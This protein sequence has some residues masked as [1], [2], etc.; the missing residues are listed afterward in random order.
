MQNML[1][2]LVIMSLSAGFVVLLVMI[3]RL[4]LKKAPRQ[5][6][7]ALWILV[8]IRL[9]IPVLPVSKDSIVPRELNDRKGIE[10]LTG[11]YI[12]ETVAVGEKDP[13]FNEIVAQNTVP[14]REEAGQRVAV[15]SR[16]ALAEGRYASPKTVKTAWLPVI[17]LIWCI[18]LGGMLL[19]M[20]FSF[21]RVR[22]KVRV[23]VPLDEKV[24]ACDDIQSPFILGM[25]RPRIYLPLSLSE[26]D[27]AYVLAHEKTHIRRGDTLWK[28]FGFLLLS[29]YWFNPLMWV[30]YIFLCRDIEMACDEAVIKEETHDYRK[31]Y[32]RALLDCSLPRR[33]ITACPLAFG[34][35][36][37][38]SRVKSVLNYRKP[39]FWLVIGALLICLIAAGC[40][41]T[42]PRKA[43]EQETVSEQ[44]VQT[45]EALVK[46][47]KE[48]HDIICSYL[49]KNVFSLYMGAGHK[50]V[51]TVCDYYLLDIDQKNIYLLASAVDYKLNEENQVIWAYGTEQ[52][53]K[54]VRLTYR[55]W[56]GAFSVVSD[57]V[58]GP[59]EI[60]EM[61]TNFTATAREVLDKVNNQTTW[62]E[63]E[64]LSYKRAC[65]LFGTEYIPG[66]VEERRPATE[67]RLYTREELDAMSEMELWEL[68]I[69]RGMQV[70]A[71]LREVQTEE[72]LAA[73]FRSSFFAWLPF[74]PPLPYGYTGYAKL[75]DEALWVYPLLVGEEAAARELETWAGPMEVEQP[76]REP[77]P[78]YPA[79]HLYTLDELL[80]MP[81]LDLVN[82]FL[83]RG[84][85]VD[86]DL[87]DT[88]VPK[89]LDIPEAN[90]IG[91][92][93][94]MIRWFCSSYPEVPRDHFGNEVYVG[95]EMYE[96]VVDELR[97]VYP[98]I[99][100][101]E[102]ESTETN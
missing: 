27:R 2:Q 34:E 75:R 54:D 95:N 16:E 57:W 43:Q 7:C 89:A 32:S 50:Y 38:K 35:N 94:D 9:L 65:E 87:P 12:E 11:R 86:I 78:T 88:S 36:A 101:E 90:I 80:P 33:M 15:V 71:G 72:Q 21:L 61:E 98:L 67:L 45:V 69:S 77:E 17:T 41:L 18:G 59:G 51:T 55:Y 74:T 97:R 29:V 64:E 85:K 42:N 84:M 53:P 81:A 73:L 60:H 19:Y 30:A 26:E 62:D 10:E 63:L 39:A 5:L 66:K 92:F 13:L 49:E 52:L 14:V 4:I 37:V 91:E 83:S 76:T 3:L 79:D 99:V 70:D 31:A 56:E 25:I 23:S 44:D 1:L 20:L 96:A 82:L 47:D 58:L 102:A 68:F 24:L 48:V 93:A 100:G 8:G 28:P 46:T 40:T 22:R 6:I